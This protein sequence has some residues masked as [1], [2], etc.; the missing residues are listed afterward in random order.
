MGLRTASRRGIALLLSE[1]SSGRFR[2]FCRD[3]VLYQGVLGEAGIAAHGASLLQ[4]GSAGQEAAGRSLLLSPSECSRQP[5]HQTA[6]G[7]VAQAARSPPKGVE[8]KRLLGASFIAE[9]LLGQPT[10]PLSQRDEAQAAHGCGA[11]AL[12]FSLY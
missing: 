3:A 9:E 1:C 4:E 10:A 6:Q 8:I 5:A 2:L 7:I 11:R 12:F